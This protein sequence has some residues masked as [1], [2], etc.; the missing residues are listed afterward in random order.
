MRRGS[1]F[2]KMRKQGYLCFAKLC[3]MLDSTISL[4]VRTST[5]LEEEHLRLGHIGI[6]KLLKF[7]GEG[8]L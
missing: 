4:P 7:A 1:E 3:T 6:T 5:P 2:I 8:L